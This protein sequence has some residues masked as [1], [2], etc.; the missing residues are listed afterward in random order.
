VATI[1]C[2]SKLNPSQ[3]KTSEASVKLNID[4]GI[5]MGAKNWQISFK[6]FSIGLAVS[7]L[8][9]VSVLP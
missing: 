7:S 1:G 4:G 5:N 2:I 8:M 9:N 3:H 6:K